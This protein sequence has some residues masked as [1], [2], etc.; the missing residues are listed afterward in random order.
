MAEDPSVQGQ[1]ARELVKV[2]WHH[3][4][5]G[6]ICGCL[7]VRKPCGGS[8]GRLIAPCSVGVPGTLI[9]PMTSEPS[10]LVRAAV[11]SY[12]SG[13]NGVAPW[14]QAHQCE[15]PSTSPRRREGLRSAAGMLL[16]GSGHFLFPSVLPLIPCCLLQLGLG[17][18]SDGYLYIR[19]MSGRHHVCLSPSIKAGL[20][21]GW[22]GICKHPSAPPLPRMYPINPSKLRCWWTGSGKT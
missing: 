14:D 3:S 19:V 5:L 21:K 20:A 7:G 18:C 13:L 1:L 2:F 10:L 16:C 6:E 4:S 17:L 15:Y 8:R 22:L 9:P 11:P 12:Q